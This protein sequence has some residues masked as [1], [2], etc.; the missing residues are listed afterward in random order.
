MVVQGWR[1]AVTLPDTTGWVFFVDDMPDANW[2]HPARIVFVRA[3]NG[4]DVTFDVTTPPKD[5]GKF[6]EF[7]TYKALPRAAKQRTPA[8]PAPKPQAGDPRPGP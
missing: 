2:E 4:E 6:R 5:F 3:D 7:G 1:K 8:L